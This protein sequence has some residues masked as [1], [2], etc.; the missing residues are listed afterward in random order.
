LKK[1]PVYDNMFFFSFPS[2]GFFSRSQAPAWECV[3]ARSPG[4]GQSPVTGSRGFPGK[5]VPKL[6]LGNEKRETR[7]DL[8]NR[9]TFSRSQAPAWERVCARSPGFGQSPVTGSRGFPG[10]CVPKLGLGNEKRF[11]KSFYFML[12]SDKRFAKS[13]YV[14]FIWKKQ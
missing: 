13:F 7:N 3:C 1:D 12:D 6:G 9:F 11:A 2:P 5:C 4:F 10:K 8:Q 14:T